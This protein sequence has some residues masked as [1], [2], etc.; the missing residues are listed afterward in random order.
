MK[1]FAAKETYIRGPE[2]AVIQLCLDTVIVTI[3]LWNVSG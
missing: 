1:S 2:A 3:V